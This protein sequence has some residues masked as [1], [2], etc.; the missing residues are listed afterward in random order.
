MTLELGQRSELKID[1][2][3]RTTLALFAG[4]AGDR[5]PIHIDIDAAHAA[6]LPDVFAHGMLSLAY[7]A[8]LITSWMPQKDLIELSVRFTAVTPVH[9]APVITG[10]VA[11]TYEEDGEQ[12]ARLS[13]IA[14]LNDGTKTLVGHAIVRNSR[15]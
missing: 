15:G 8:R 7:V 10:E 1:P 12:R 13:L 6:G 11:E 2:I 14:Q 5:N 4:A 3:S 9:G